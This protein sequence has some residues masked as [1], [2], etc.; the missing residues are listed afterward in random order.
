MYLQTAEIAR[1]ANTA[2]TTNALVI[3]VK[4]VLCLCG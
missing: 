3:L 4:V 2:R 1:T